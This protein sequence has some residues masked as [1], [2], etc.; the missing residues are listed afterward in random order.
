[1]KEISTFYWNLYG[2]FTFRLKSLLSRCFSTVPSL[3][4]WNLYFLFAF[5]LKP[6]LLYFSIE[7]SIVSLLFYCPCTF[8]LKSLLSFHFS[9]EISTFF[10]LFHWNLPLL[11]LYFSFEIS[12]VSLLFDWNLYFLFAFVLKPLLLY[13]SIEISIVCLLFY[14]PFT[15]HWNLYFLSTCQLKSLLSFY[16]SI[17]TCLYF[18]FTFLLKSLL[19]LYLSFEISTFS[20][21]FYWNLYFLFTFLLESHPRVCVFLCPDPQY[22]RPRGVFVSCLGAAL[23]RWWCILFE[24]YAGVIFNQHLISTA[25]GA[26]KICMFFFFRFGCSPRRA[27]FGLCSR[28]FLP[29]SLLST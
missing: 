20:L 18:L 3:L 1:M 19:S 16:F 14:C 10:L 22:I 9:V 6:L 13:F 26:N 12:T 21:L 8:A 23:G 25:C 17:E 5:V 27:W 7:I 11:S 24:V 29:R 28:R 15:L 4:H 2:L